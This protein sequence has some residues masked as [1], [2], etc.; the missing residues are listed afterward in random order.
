M[1]G[2]QDSDEYKIVMRQARRMKGEGDDMQ[3]EQ[4]DL[5][6]AEDEESEWCRDGRFRESQQGCE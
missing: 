6:D 1:K 2:S 4:D 3:D 5:G